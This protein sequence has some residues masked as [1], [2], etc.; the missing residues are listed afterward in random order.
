MLFCL[1]GC[2]NSVELNFNE[3]IKSFIAELGY[4]IWY[5]NKLIHFKDEPTETWFREKY[6]H[7]NIDLPLI[8]KRLMPLG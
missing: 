3:D 8:I 2:A 1:T 6:G 5:H 7:Q 4:P